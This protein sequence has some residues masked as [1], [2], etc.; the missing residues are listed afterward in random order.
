MPGLGSCAGL[1]YHSPQS[2]QPLKFRKASMKKI[3][4]LTVLLVIVTSGCTQINFPYRIDVEQ[5]NVLTQDVIDRLQPGMDR[6]Q[7]AFLLGTP[8]ITNDFRPERWDY[9]YSLR[10]GQGVFLK[11]HMVMFFHGDTL[12][13]LEGDMRPGGDDSAIADE[14]DKRLEKQTEKPVKEAPTTQ[15]EEYIRERIEE[16]GGDQL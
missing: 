15:Q 10:T 9:Y 16:T 12:V 2:F 3:A 4:T 7:V 8:L 6:R 14:R 5:G 11:R 13:R 1:Q